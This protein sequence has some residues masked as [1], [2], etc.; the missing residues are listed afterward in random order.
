MLARI[1]SSSTT[2]FND[3]IVALLREGAL[4]ALARAPAQATMIDVP[5]ALEIATA[6]AIALDDAEL[7]GAP[8]DG[9]VALGCV[10]R[11]DTYHFELVANE[12]TRALIESFRLAPPAARQWRAHRGE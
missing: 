4:D 7:A 1:F 6:A 5:G 8:Y 11:G 10:I 2:N 3:D 9:V 12:S